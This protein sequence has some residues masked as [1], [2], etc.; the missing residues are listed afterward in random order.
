VLPA[1]AQPAQTQPTPGLAGFGAEGGDFRAT[2]TDGRILR[3][4]DLVGAALNLTQDGQP[5]AL[6]IDA[7]ERDADQPD[8]WLFTL[9]TPG[10]QNYCM[11]DPDGRS[12]AIPYPEAGGGF[13]LTCS[14]GATGK[15]IRFGYRPWAMSGDGEVSLAPFH[16]ACVNMLRAAY[17]GPEHA[18]TRDGMRIDVYDRIGIQAP[19]NDAGQEFEAGWNAAG[20]VC[21]AHPRVPENGGLVA[22]AAEAPGLPLGAACTEGVAQARGALVFNRSTPPG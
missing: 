1:W 17:A 10:G 19:A 13:G 20:A 4:A 8:V 16:A 3:G 15:C 12:L 21:V 7:A 11:P 6:R 18:W 22:I 9:T 2:L 14:S 5:L